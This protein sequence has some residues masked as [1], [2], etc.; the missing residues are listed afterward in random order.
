MDRLAIRYHS[1][2]GDRA[3]TFC[4]YEGGESG[5][6]SGL[7]RCRESGELSG[8]GFSCDDNRQSLAHLTPLLNQYLPTDENT[9]VTEQ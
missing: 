3:N 7:V 1:V 5:E 4:I 2:F 6:L 9:I 8:L